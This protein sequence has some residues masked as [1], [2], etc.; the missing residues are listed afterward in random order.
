MGLTLTSTSTLTRRFVQSN[1]N[2]KQLDGVEDLERARRELEQLLQ[3][4]STTTETT[5]TIGATSSTQSS[6][7]NENDEFLLSCAG[8][9]R[10]YVELELL[11][12]LRTSDEAIDA[13]MHVWIHECPADIHAVDAIQV[14]QD[15]CHDLQ[16]AETVLLQIA[17]EH[18]HWPEP[19]SRLALLWFVQ[20]RYDEC[21]RSV[22]RVLQQKPWHFEALQMQVLL[23]LVLKAADDDNDKDHSWAA[24]LPYARRGLPPLQQRNRRHRWVDWAVQQAQQ[25]L[26]RLEER[27]DR[28]RAAVDQSESSNESVWQ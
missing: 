21:E 26:L 15:S 16:H 20:G 24:A 6:A 25:Q 28:A 17:Q 2:S 19:H 8:R 18:R 1:S 5:V 7:P 10:R 3:S 22:Q 9:Q 4:T 23:Q 13:L 27:D 11:E 14:L 12:S